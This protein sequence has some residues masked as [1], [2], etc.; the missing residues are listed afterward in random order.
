MRSL[1]CFVFVGW[2]VVRRFAWIDIDSFTVNGSIR[3]ALLALLWPDEGQ[4]QS[5]SVR[6]AQTVSGAA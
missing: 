2:I 5:A 3:L 6:D 4:G 1:L